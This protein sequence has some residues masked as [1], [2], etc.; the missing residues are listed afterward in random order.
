MRLTQVADL[1]H[2]VS[3]AKKQTLPIKS[4]FTSINSYFT[5]IQT[6]QSIPA[7]EIYFFTLSN[8]FRHKMRADV[9]IYIAANSV[10]VDLKKTLFPL[11]QSNNK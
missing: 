1:N 5:S 6:Q 9:Y 2:L 3:P 8:S 4:Y 11:N 7:T 10:H